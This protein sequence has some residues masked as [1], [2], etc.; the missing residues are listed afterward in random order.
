[1]PI[2]QTTAIHPWLNPAQS[3][4]FCGLAASADNSSIVHREMF[5]QLKRR[6]S[7][8]H[9]MAMQQPPAVERP[10]NKT[11]GRLLS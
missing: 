3:I 1:M 9:L 6:C 8:S 4:M 11:I 7:M 10:A 2:R 5:E